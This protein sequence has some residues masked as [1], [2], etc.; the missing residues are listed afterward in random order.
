MTFTFSLPHVEGEQLSRLCAHDRLLETSF[1]PQD[2]ARVRL[3]AGDSLSSSNVRIQRVEIPS[4]ANVPIGPGG[5]GVAVPT[6]RRVEHVSSRSGSRTPRENFMKREWTKA[7]EFSALALLLGAT[8]VLPVAA[9][10][11]AGDAR[12]SDDRDRGSA[13][14][15]DKHEAQDNRQRDRDKTDGRDNAQDRRGARETDRGDRDKNDYPSSSRPTQYPNSPDYQNN[16]G[17]N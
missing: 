14:G 8:S 16:S 3:A 10:A 11:C 2:A 12:R 4:A 9:P 17:V 5:I 6:Q 15:E 7:A 13:Y 1:S